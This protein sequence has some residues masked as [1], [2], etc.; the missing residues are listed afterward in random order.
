MGYISADAIRLTCLI[1]RL[2]EVGTDVLLQLT[3]GGKR[4]IV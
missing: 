3:N 1:A 4:R 2:S